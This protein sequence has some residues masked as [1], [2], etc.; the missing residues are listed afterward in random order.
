MQTLDT[1]PPKDLSIIGFCQQLQ[2]L[3]LYGVI[4]FIPI[5]IAFSDICLTLLLLSTLLETAV[6]RRIPWPRSPLDRQLVV[7]IL[8]TVGLTPFAVD[9]AKSFSKLTNLIDVAI[10]FLLY[11]VIKEQQHIRQYVATLILS[12]SITS[13]YGALQHY[14]EIDLFRFSQPIS[15]LKHINNDLSAPV[16]I[17]GF[18]SYMTFGGQLA[19]ILPFVFAFILYSQKRRDKI[20]WS[21]VFIINGSALIWTYTRSAWI[22]S[23]LAMI[24]IGFMAKGKQFWKYLFIATLLL[25]IALVLQQSLNYRPTAPSSSRAENLH[26]SQQDILEP[27]ESQGPI[28]R[29]LGSY[30]VTRILSIFDMENNLERLYTWESSLR[31]IADHP[32]TG[33]GHG[34]Y[35]KTCVS[36]RTHY[37]D[38]EFTS[39]AHAHNVL[40]QIATIGGLPL[41]G[42]FLWLWLTL[43]R[44]IYQRYYHTAVEDWHSRALT[45]GVFGALIAFSVHGMFEHNFGDSEVLSMLWLLCALSLALPSGPPSTAEKEHF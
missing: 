32:L 10:F 7:F 8:V 37:G 20:L 42:A 21:A 25:G 17:S 9:A 24:A 43:F 4:F 19:M 40:I 22:G 34:N 38:F 31:M 45:L 3:S 6:S 41:L 18:S 14:L 12:M 13:L 11:M 33:I 39:R 44:S 30:I 1:I 26:A 5:S 23:I 36:Y 16:R 35:S 28:K 29:M 15:F 27:L 2:T